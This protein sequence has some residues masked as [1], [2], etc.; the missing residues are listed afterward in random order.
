MDFVGVKASSK[1][2]SKKKVRA[3]TNM[4]IPLFSCFNR[5]E[6]IKNIIGGKR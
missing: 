1:K 5:V 4:I 2:M 3:Y 6:K